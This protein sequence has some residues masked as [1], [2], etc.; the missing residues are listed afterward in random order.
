M[1]ASDL[2]ARAASVC[3]LAN[4][5]IGSWTDKTTWVLTPAPSATPQQLAALPAFIASVDPTK[6]TLNDSLTAM[7]FTNEELTA[8]FFVVAGSP[9]AWATA[10]VQAAVAARQPVV[11][12]SAVSTPSAQ[13]VGT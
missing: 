1:Q 3:P 11:A 13:A 5:S 8:L 9:P 2:I 7:P 12:A 10:A 4:V 6:P